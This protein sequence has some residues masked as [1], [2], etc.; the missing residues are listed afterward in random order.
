MAAKASRKVNRWLTPQPWLKA[1]G[2]STHPSTFRPRWVC[3][4]FHQGKQGFH[5]AKS[6]GEISAGH[7]LLALVAAA[8]LEVSQ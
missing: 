8:A 4:P 3:L 6:P 5:L 7:D 2:A 1:C